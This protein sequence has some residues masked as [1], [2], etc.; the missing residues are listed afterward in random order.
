MRRNAIGLKNSSGGE[1][2]ERSSPI[3]GDSRKRAN[4]GE[5][6]FSQYSAYISLF[7]G[8]Y[9]P[10]YNRIYQLKLPQIKPKFPVSR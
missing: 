9:T 2:P 7:L 6:Y 1:E 10:Q 5:I 4:A 8:R 3:A